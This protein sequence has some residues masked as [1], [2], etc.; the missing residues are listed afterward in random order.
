MV[1]NIRERP[2]HARAPAPRPAHQPA[3]GAHPQVI[4]GAVAQAEFGVVGL[5]AAQ[6]VGQLGLEGGQV[7]RMQQAQHGFTRM[8]QLVVVVT[9][10]LRA[11]RREV[12]FATTKMPVP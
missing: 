6:M 5:A 8:R 1:G 2:R 4:A 10:H 11:A 7:G 12:E 3:A 9:E